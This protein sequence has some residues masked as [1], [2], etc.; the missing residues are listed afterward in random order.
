[1]YC[2]ADKAKPLQSPKRDAE[3]AAMAFDPET[4]AQRL[5]RENQ[6]WEMQNKALQGSQ[7]ANNLEDMAATSEVAKGF[8]GALQSAANLQFGDAIAQTGRALKPVATGQN[9]ATR[10][11]IAQILMSSDPR[12]ALAPVLRQD[13]QS[14]TMRRIIEAITRNAGREGYISGV[15]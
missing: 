7:T 14:Q 12:A 15:N 6:M 2:R 11:L 4:Y 13:M 10:K 9:E 8:G 3:A 5:A 1:M